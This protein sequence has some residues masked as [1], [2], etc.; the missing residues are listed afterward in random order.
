MK[1]T[2]QERMQEQK[3]LTKLYFTKTYLDLKKGLENS[4]RRSTAEGI[5]QLDHS[6]IVL[7][8]ARERFESKLG[9]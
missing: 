7:E 2:I 8:E 3:D 6:E 4:K 1:K 5:K 9:N